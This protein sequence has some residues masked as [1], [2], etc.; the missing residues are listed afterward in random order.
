MHTGRFHSLIQVVHFFNQGGDGPGMM[1]TNE[2][3]PLGLGAD[4]EQDLAAFLAAL[5]G[6]GPD[7]PLL[8]AP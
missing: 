8:K 1:G 2:L 3:K 5:D 4:E 6:P 7:A